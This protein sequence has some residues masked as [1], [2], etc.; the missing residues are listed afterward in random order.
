MRKLSVH[1]FHDYIGRKIESRFHKPQ[2]VQSSTQT[3][4]RSSLEGVSEGNSTLTIA[5]SLTSSWIVR[6][7]DWFSHNDRPAD[8][9]ICT[10]DAQ[11][12]EQ[13][14]EHALHDIPVADH[15]CTR[16]ESISELTASGS[17]YVGVVAYKLACLV[18][19]PVT[20]SAH[21]G[22]EDKSRAFIKGPT[23]P[24]EM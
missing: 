3:G 13:V 23:G 5:F 12:K 1:Q 24:D 10:V 2:T 20:I 18:E 22:G 9:P 14:I 15:A 17:I 7:C 11:L 4:S 16:V 21:N 6:V 19:L 8:T